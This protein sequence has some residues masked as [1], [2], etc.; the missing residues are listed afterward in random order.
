MTIEE[1]FD[2]FCLF[3][4]SF[5][6]DW[7]AP[8]RTNVSTRLITRIWV[9]GTCRRTWDGNCCLQLVLNIV[10]PRRFEIKTILYYPAIQR[11]L[12]LTHLSLCI[13]VWYIPVD[14][15]HSDS[16]IWV[17]F[18]CFLTHFWFINNCYYFFFVGH[19]IELEWYCYETSRQLIS[20]LQS[21]F[22]F[23][24]WSD[25]HWTV[26]VQLSHRT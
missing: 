16:W 5:H 3:L 14:T 18:I 22:L 13:S 11:H 20:T 6:L 2:I 15:L 1:I 10:F 24:F 19:F 17:W 4:D 12:N 9:F 8:L 25:E 7:E 23:I 26:R 21:I